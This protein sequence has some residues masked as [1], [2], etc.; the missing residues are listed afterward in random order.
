METN[1]GYVL[2]EIL[3]KMQVT[4][5]SSFKKLNGRGKIYRD[6]YIEISMMNFDALRDWSL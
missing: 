1:F 2:G 6:T 3:P 4:E 5:L